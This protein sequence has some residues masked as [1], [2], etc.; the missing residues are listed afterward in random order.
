MSWRLQSNVGVPLRKPST[1]PFVEMMIV[2]CCVNLFLPTSAYS[3]TAAQLC[4]RI[5]NVDL[6]EF[7]AW[8]L[9]TEAFLLDMCAHLFKEA[10][11]FVYINLGKDLQLRKFA[12]IAEFIATQEV[13][14]SS[15]F[16]LVERFEITEP[17]GFALHMTEDIYPRV[18]SRPRSLEIGGRSR[19]PAYVRASRSGR[20]NVGATTA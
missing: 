7:D 18:S 2:D 20:A 16:D 3:V 11:T 15:F 13:D 17:I 4:D 8:C 1:D 19:V 10:T 9:D 12:D 14:W 6:G 5:R